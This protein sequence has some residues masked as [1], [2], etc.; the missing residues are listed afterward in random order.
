M[1][2]TLHELAKHYNADPADIEAMLAS[3]PDD[4]LGLW[5]G[6]G[7]LSDVAAYEVSE[8][9]GRCSDRPL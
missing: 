7:V 8:R 2:H 9:R 4:E 1:T 3:Y 6:V 5:S